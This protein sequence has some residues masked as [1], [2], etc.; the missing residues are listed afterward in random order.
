MDKLGKTDDPVL[1]EAVLGVIRATV[2]APQ[3][4]VRAA[5]TVFGSGECA[6]WRELGCSVF[7]AASEASLFLTA[8]RQWT[9]G[10]RTT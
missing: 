7:V 4:G 10:V 6:A 3:P 2:S 8:A 9:A 1:R 5:M